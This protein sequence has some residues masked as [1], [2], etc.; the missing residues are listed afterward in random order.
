MPVIT[1]DH[2]G[3]LSPAG[4]EQPYLSFYF[5][6]N[7]R[8]LAGQFVGDDLVRGY[9]AAVEILESLLLTGLETGGFSEYLLDS[10]NP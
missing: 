1:Y 5:V 9:G 3:Y 6:G 7:C 2:T 8:N 10:L 4:Y